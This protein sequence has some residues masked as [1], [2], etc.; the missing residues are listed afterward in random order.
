[1]MVAFLYDVRVGFGHTSLSV[2]L[3]TLNGYTE[4]TI[5]VSPTIS[6]FCD[7]VMRLSYI[8]SCAGIKKTG[9]WRLA[10]FLNG[11]QQV[12]SSF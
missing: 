5:F 4:H 8:Q 9:F 2:H 6:S 1:M 10:E 12:F 7:V 11:F 3:H